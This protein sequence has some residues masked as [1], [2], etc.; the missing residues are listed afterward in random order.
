M[1][2]LMLD[3]ETAPHVSYTWGLFDQNIGLSQ[4]VTPGHILCWSASWHHEQ[5]AMYGSIQNRTRKQMLRGLHVVLDQADVV[6]GWNSK[7]FDIPWIQGEFIQNGF[8]PPLPFK[9]VDLFQVSKS[10]FKFASHKLAFVAP[11][12]AQKEKIKTDFDLWRDV[13]NNDPK[14]WAKMEAYC[15]RDVLVLH[16]IYNAMLPWIKNHPAYHSE[17]GELV[18]RNCGSYHIH[19]RGSTKTNAGVYALYQCQDCGKYGRS[20]ANILLPVDR[21]AILR[22]V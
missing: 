9:Q 10:Q 4:L 3:I 7:Q 16:D 18:C 21:A 15:K 2:I 5:G 14:A 8:K 12:L 13:M 19:R 11:L 22:E 20:P 17:T 6:I 1:N